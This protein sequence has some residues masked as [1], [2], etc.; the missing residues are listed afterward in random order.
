MSQDTDNQARWTVLLPCMLAMLA[1]ANL[2]YAWTLFTTDLTKAFHVRLDAVQWTL[3]FFTIAQTA[4]F[5]LNSYLIDRFG[6]RLIVALASVAVAVGWVG[7][8]LVNSL[9]ALYIVYALGGIG[10][11]AVYG[12][13]I[14][15]AMKWFPDRRGLCVGLVAGSYGF[16]TALTARPVAYLIE[17][18]GYRT[19][20]IVFGAI[21]GVVVL[22]AAQFLKMP[23]HGWAPAGWEK[24]KATL[25]KK[26][27]QSS[28]DCTPAQMLRS[29]SFY[30]LYLMMTLV[31][32]SGLMLTYQLK[33]IA[34]SY[35]YDRFALFGG[36]TILTF[37]LSLNQVL[38]GSARPFF[39]WVSDR[40]GRY[41][42]MAIVFVL[43]AITIFALTLV[44]ARPFW[45]I[46]TSALMFFAWG[47]IYSLFPAAIADIFGSRHATTN[48]GIQYTAKGVGS[49]LAGPAAAWLMTRYGSW[50]PVFWAAVACNV[51]AA[52]LAVLWL[53]PR[54]AR[55]AFAELSSAPPAAAARP[56]AQVAEEAAPD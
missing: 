3:T 56:L 7:A 44:V 22:A 49:I 39:G 37:T 2:Q 36:F 19:A 28:C 51:M 29:G 38:N 16:G 55:L 42:T 47:D 45:F 30:L 9:P 52:A 5:P 6:P 4:L 17:H 34:V 24:I 20:F 10:A 21:Q 48:Y 31:T 8:G 18:Q 40:I 54:V 26:V 43:E 12:G 32:A 15:V 11:G 25:L 50:T 41:D 35:G 53:K 1:V 46:V 14:G 13:C 33:P 23:P 27:F